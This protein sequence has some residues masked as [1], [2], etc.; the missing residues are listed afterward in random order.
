MRSREFIRALWWIETERLIEIIS[1][2]DNLSTCELVNVLAAI[3]AAIFLR[4]GSEKI[5]ARSPPR[6]FVT[7][8]SGFDYLDQMRPIAPVATSEIT[9]LTRNGAL[10]FFEVKS[11]YRKKRFVT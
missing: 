6:G 8:S 4:S 5:A 7:S 9:I 3:A 10:D 2:F 1:V 11:R